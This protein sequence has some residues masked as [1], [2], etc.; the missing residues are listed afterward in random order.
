VSVF[1]ISDWYASFAEH[2]F[3]TVFVR[4]NPAEIDAL[5]RQDGDAEATRGLI[6]RLG[7]AMA[8]LPGSSFVSADVCAPTDSALFRPGHGTTNARTAWQL[9]A[10]SAKVRQALQERRSERLT[11]RPFRRMDR[12]REFRLFF[13]A[14]Q[15]AGMSQYHLD[16]HVTRLARRQEEIWE[17][18]CRFAATVRAFLPTD[19][20]AMDA[21]LTS[22]AQFLIID[23]NP[24]GAPTDPLLFRTWERD[25]K[26]VAG[27]RIIPPPVMMKG[28]VSVSF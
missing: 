5:R 20:V 6:E 18:A 21:Y 27:L 12:I 3:P 8:S 4:L 7:L 17:R 10:A 11:V 23:L 14:R 15:L 16:R 2:T 19:H 22:R 13:H 25:W 1:A 9:L 24:W 26:E 28:D